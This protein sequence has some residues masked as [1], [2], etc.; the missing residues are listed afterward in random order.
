MIEGIQIFAL[1]HCLLMGFSHLLQPKV[2]IEFFIFL[3]DKGHIG[4]F[5]NGFLSLAF[6]SVIVAFHPVWHGL[7][8]ILT[9]VGW[10]Q[11]IKA[12]ICFLFPSIGLRSLHLVDR[13][14]PNKFRI[15]G[16]VLLAIAGVLAYSLLGS[17]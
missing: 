5:I 15:A 11:L 10:A 7:A 13:E 17:S 1:I 8:I 3:R 16:I 6:G 12:S 4:V 14:Q 9:L 2:W